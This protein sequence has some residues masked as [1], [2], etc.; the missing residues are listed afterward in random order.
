MKLYY[1]YQH[2]LYFILFLFKVDN[3]RSNFFNREIDISSSWSE[4]SRSEAKSNK[5]TDK[6]KNNANNSITNNKKGDQHFKK[7]KND[8]RGNKSERNNR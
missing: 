6:V 4:L 3:L 2:L 5:V 1:K 7:T 8:Q